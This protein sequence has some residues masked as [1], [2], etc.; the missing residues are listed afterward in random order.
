MKNLGCFA[1]NLVTQSIEQTKF[2][3][4]SACSVYAQFL[5][6][7]SFAFFVVFKTVI[8]PNSLSGGNLEAS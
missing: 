3:L 5:F 2:S 6:V 4:V 1:T 8:R 7:A